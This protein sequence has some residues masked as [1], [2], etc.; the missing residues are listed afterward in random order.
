MGHSH[1]PTQELGVKLEGNIILMEYSFKHN[2]AVR[3]K[4][5]WSKYQVCP[6]IFLWLSGT[7][8]WWQQAKKG[9]YSPKQH[10][11]G[12]I[13][14]IIPPACSGSTLG[15]T[16]SWTCPGFWWDAGNAS[17]GSI[18]SGA[19]S[20]AQPPFGGNSF[21]HSNSF[22]HYLMTIGESLDIQ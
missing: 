1:N 10:F 9:I 11:P 14:Y 17:T 2:V 16:T 18:W 19:R 7:L 12:Q 8:S 13:R 6:S 21:W 4:K 3:Y 15:S 20:W 5:G 22:S